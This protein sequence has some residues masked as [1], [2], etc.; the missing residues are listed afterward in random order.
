MML[1]FLFL[2]ILNFYLLCG[3]HVSC[4]MAVSGT[5]HSKATF[6]AS[7]HSGPAGNTSFRSKPPSPEVCAGVGTCST[8]PPKC[9]TKSLMKN[10]KV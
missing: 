1:L 3:E 7:L 4:V 9:D 10:T 6:R 2:L 8:A 5:L